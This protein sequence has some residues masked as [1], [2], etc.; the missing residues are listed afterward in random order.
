M[1]LIEQ[2]RNN[3]DKL[4]TASVMCAFDIIGREF[5]NGEISF[6]NHSDDIYELIELFEL[7]PNEIIEYIVDNKHYNSKDLFISFDGEVLCSFPDLDYFKYT[8]MKK[9]NNECAN[10]ILNEL[11]KM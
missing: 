9:M 6:I 8:I 2:A 7:P 10:F 3:L 11:N 5:L 4:P 1:D